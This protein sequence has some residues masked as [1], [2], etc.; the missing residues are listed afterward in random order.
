MS[1]SVK[2]VFI[3]VPFLILVGSALSSIVMGARVSDVGAQVNTL[4]SKYLSLSKSN[5]DMVLQLAQKQSLAV[6]KSQAASLGF[7]PRTSVVMVGSP[8]LAKAN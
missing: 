3:I 1:T 4:E 5:Q 8:K 6:I 7:V 2:V